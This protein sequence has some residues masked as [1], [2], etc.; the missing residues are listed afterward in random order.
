MPKAIK[1]TSNKPP[2]A[3]AAIKGLRE[4]SEAE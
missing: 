3:A 4:F 1:I 2:M